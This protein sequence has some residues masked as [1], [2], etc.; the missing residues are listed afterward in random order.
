MNCKCLTQRLTNHRNASQLRCYYYSNFTVTRKR[1][2]LLSFDP[3]GFRINVNSL[4]LRNVI[5]MHV[6]LVD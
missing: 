6:G 4:I 5:A 1:R 3:S 2:N